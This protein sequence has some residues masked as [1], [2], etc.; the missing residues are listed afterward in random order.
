[1]Q[2]MRDEIF[3][4][5]E[6]DIE[7]GT[8]ELLRILDNKIDEDTA[9]NILLKCSS[10][11]YTTSL[12][13]EFSFERLIAHLEPYALDYFDN[14]ALNE[15]YAYLLSKNPRA[16]LFH[17]SREFSKI[18][19]PSGTDEDEMEDGYGEFGHEITN[20]IPT[21]SIIQSS[22]YL[23]RLRTIDDLEVTYEREG[24]KQVDN[25]NAPVDIYRIYVNEKQIA[26]LHIC[27]YNKRT[28]T[29]APNGFKLED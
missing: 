8:N 13:D 3:P 7:D 18:S 1:M 20:P 11:C 6:K 15:F 25:I 4:N 21:A 16:Y 19:N 29:Q 2:R 26:T 5:G 17:A 27:P 9:K 10:I 23:D 24:S 28:S 12:R 22:F 14:E